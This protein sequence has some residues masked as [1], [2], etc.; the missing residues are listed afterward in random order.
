VSLKEEAD[1]GLQLASRSDAAI[2]G[3]S[4]D[5]EYSSTV[6]I[7]GQANRDAHQRSFAGQCLTPGTV[8]M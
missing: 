4:K 7:S 2:P 3:L 8:V 5:Q 6:F 1:Q